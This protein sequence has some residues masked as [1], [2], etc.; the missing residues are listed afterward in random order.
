MVIKHRAPCPIKKTETPLTCCFS[1]LKNDSKGP[2][3]NPLIV[4]AFEGVNPI[5]LTLSRLEK[6]KGH[7][8][9]ID[10]VSKLKDKYP[11]ILYV[12]AGTGKELSNLQKLVDKLKIDNHVIFVGVVNE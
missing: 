9:V 5:I 11:D 1:A 6:R 12:I 4:V 3:A 10:A 7:K 2:N 8:Y